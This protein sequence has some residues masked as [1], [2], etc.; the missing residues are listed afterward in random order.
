M[1]IARTAANGMVSRSLVWAL[2][3]F[4]A[5]AAAAEAPQPEVLISA[6]ELSRRLAE[7]GL[8][9]VDVRGEKRY[10]AGHLPTAVRL[11]SPSSLMALGRPEV[12]ERMGELGLD[13]SETVVLYGQAAN[14]ADVGAAFLV[15]E[16]AGVDEVRVLDG[17]LTAWTALG[18]DLE[19]G[20]EHLPPKVFAP[21][22]IRRTT[23][24]ADAILSQLGAAD[25]AIVDVRAGRGWQLYQPT[26]E[27]RAGHV[28]TA[29]L[30]DFSI[31]WG[32]DG[33]G[34]GLHQ[35]AKDELARL[36]PRAGTGV[37][38]NGRFIV[39]GADAGDPRSALGYMT[40]R[41]LGLNAQVYRPGWA[42]WT[43]G[44]ARPVVK[45]VG[46]QE[47]K[48]LERTREVTHG[49]PFFERLP[50]FDLREMRDWEVGH[51]PGAYPL[52]PGEFP[53]FF[54]MV[55]HRYWPAADPSRD[56]LV[57]YCYGPDCTR[58]R[59]GIAVA[60]GDGWHTI[61]WFRGGI[62]SWFEAGYPLERLAPEETPWRQ[63]TGG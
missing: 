35:D 14:E 51:V 12:E 26:P 28:P 22:R 38:L 45:I 40:L 20:V 33:A 27:F 15:L 19:R 13:G 17:G 60:A 63:E 49:T 32:G 61:Y 18:R 10:S 11:P 4:S 7:P 50:I 24:G 44:S 3:L 31:L 30:Y 58:S 59:Q 21:S 37:A 41:A 47:L 9:V 23:V 29:L 48:A 39:Y 25:T 16:S 55:L 56:P 1:A 36:G 54:Q 2:S 53:R 57:V 34:P 62:A 8:E 46:P 43:S 6:Q 5:L 42:G 52:T